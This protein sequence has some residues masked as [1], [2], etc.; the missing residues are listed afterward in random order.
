MIDAKNLALKFKFSYSKRSS[1]IFIHQLLNDL[2]FEMITDF[3]AD[4]SRVAG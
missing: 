4:M 3:S 1:D 2:N